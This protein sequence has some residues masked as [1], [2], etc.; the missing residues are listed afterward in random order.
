[1]TL[2]NT[3]Y[4]ILIYIVYTVCFE[5]MSGCQILI[6]LFGFLTGCISRTR[7]KRAYIGDI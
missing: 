7:F 6:Y 5:F 4:D 3:L 2:V 1:M